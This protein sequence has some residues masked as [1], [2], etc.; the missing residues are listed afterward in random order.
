MIL[1]ETSDFKVSDV[2]DNLIYTANKDKN[3][4]K[5]FQR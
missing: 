3:Q 2:E 4:E 1:T 5:A